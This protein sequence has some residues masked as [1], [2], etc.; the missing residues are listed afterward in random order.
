MKKK[1]LFVTNHFRF[2][3][4]VASVLRS[5]IANLDMTKYD[6]SLLAIYDFNEEFAAPIMDRIKV[7]KGFGFYFRGFDKLINLIPNKMLYK[8]FVKDKY[9]L[10]VAFQFGV[11]TKM[12]AASDNPHRICWMHTYDEKMV[13]K[14]YYKKYPLVVNVARIGTEKLIKEGFN[15]SKCDYCYNIIDEENINR[16]SEETSDINCKKGKCIITVAR[17]APDKGFLRYLNCIS[18]IVKIFTDVEFWIVGDGSE[19][20][21]ME[22]FISTNNLQNNVRLLG[23]QTNP[24]KYVKNAD[25]YF[26]CSYREGFS[27][28]C[29]E[30]AILG[31]PVMSVAVDG[32]AELIEEA[33]CGK[34]IPN[35]EQA[36]TEELVAYLR[37]PELAEKW[38]IEAK[39]NKMKFYKSE[40]IRKIEAILDLIM[41]KEET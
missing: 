19:R 20:P 17:L 13:L 37:D 12:I 31:I 22:E 32:A 41:I 9:D 3:N 15:E 21:K 26:C 14:E 39:R 16:L 23:A 24:F 27:T 5:L 36:I 1:V 40:R 33:G 11:P 34:V 35:S 29:Q 7:V 8:H 25:L 30:A 10:E 2:S 28:A 38:K 6:V 4:G 18:D